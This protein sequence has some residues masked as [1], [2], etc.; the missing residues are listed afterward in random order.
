MKFF[1][2]GGSGFLGSC[3]VRKLVQNG[4]S[5]KIFDDMSRGSI[6]K[7]ED[8][9]NK[10]QIV[11]G[12]IRD[13]N[14]LLKSSKGYDY[15]IHMAAINGTTFFYSKPQDVLDVSVRG[16]LNAVE[17]SKQ[18]KIRKFIF[19]SSSEVYQQPK[20]IP[21][22]E[23]VPLIIPDVFNPRYSYGGGKIISE[24]ICLNYYKKFFE[25]MIIFRPHNVYGPDMGFEHVIPELI[26]KALEVKNGRSEKII[27]KGNGS[28]RRTFIFI[29]DFTNA[30]NKVI[31]NG[32]NRSIYHIGN[33]D[34]ITVI[35]LLKK[36][37]RIMEVKCD[38]EYSN[39]PVGETTRRCPDNKKIVDLGYVQNF[40]IENG[41]K[42]TVEW[43]ER[44]YNN[45]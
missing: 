29:N 36:I 12:D 21:T 17:V 41:L 7:I 32:I 37:L 35:E 23:N 30:L 9:K 18:N 13:E 34:E 38:I 25:K 2:T 45:A 15:F 20:K 44:F 8:L 5:I 42:K 1:I 24:L 10:I 43:Y 14:L 31:T 3:T 27:L 11:N 40:S 39:S 33:T 26:F 28:Q 16:I 4:H 19:A 6:K 22:S